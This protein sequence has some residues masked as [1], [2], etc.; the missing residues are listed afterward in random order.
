VETIQGQLEIVANLSFLKPGGV[1]LVMRN[2]PPG[3]SFEKRS[4]AAT[5]YLTEVVHAHD[6]SHICV[7]GDPDPANNKVFLVDSAKLC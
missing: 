7:T 5:A 3:G 1:R 4:Y 6:G 2:T